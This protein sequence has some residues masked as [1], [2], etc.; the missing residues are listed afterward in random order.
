MKNELL[1]YINNNNNGFITA[2][3]L[4]FATRE[5]RLIRGLEPEQLL[6]NEEYKEQLKEVLIVCINNSQLDELLKEIKS[7]GLFIIEECVNES[8]KEL[9]TKNKQELNPLECQ[10]KGII[11]FLEENINYLSVRAY[12]LLKRYIVQENIK[13]LKYFNIVDFCFFNDNVTFKILFQV[14][15]FF[16]RFGIDVFEGVGYF[17]QQKMANKFG[18]KLCGDY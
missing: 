16:E 17:Q 2:P 15:D 6:D 4:Y 3:S 11:E 18:Y 12:N 1:N 14:S 13:I 7:D 8:I 9:S 10:E 5:F